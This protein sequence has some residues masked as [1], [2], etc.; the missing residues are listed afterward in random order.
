M[1][2]SENEDFILLRVHSP[3]TGKVVSDFYY[4]DKHKV[5]NVRPLHLNSDLYIRKAPMARTDFVVKVR[6]TDQ[7]VLLKAKKATYGIIHVGNY[8]DYWDAYIWNVE[9]GKVNYIGDITLDVVE[10]T[11]PKNKKIKDYY[12]MS[13][14]DNFNEII[15]DEEIVK[16]C[17]G[18]K[19]INQSKNTDTCKPYGCLITRYN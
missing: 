1:K 17:S 7:I 4:T 9:S 10:G 11:L 19:I 12:D 6:E 2:L 5:K 16:L 15:E 14:A 8:S 3:A 18:Y 13:V